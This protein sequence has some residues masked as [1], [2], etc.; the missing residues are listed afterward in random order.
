MKSFGSWSGT[1]ANRNVAE[2]D[3]AGVNHLLDSVWIVVN[4]TRTISQS[5]TLLLRQYFCEEKCR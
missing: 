1:G 5:E 3:G 4:Q 2:L